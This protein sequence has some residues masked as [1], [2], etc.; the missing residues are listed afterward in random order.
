L[1]LWQL[2]RLALQRRGQHAFS[3]S[4]SQ[5]NRWCMA[6]QPVLHAFQCRC[7]PLMPMP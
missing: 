2:F 1:A 5:Q 3:M 4:R 7:R 6:W